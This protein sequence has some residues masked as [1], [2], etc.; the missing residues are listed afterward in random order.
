MDKK[1]EKRLE[2]YYEEEF[3]P[4]VEKGEKLLDSKHKGLINQFVEKTVTPF[5]HWEKDRKTTRTEMLAKL[6]EWFEDQEKEKQFSEWIQ[7]EGIEYTLGKDSIEVAKKDL[8]DE[9]LKEVY[10]HLKEER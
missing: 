9:E 1:E 7:S 2:E 10:K 5:F 3:K 6:K 8:D 4:K